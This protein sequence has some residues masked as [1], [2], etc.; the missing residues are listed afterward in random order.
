MKKN[1]SRIFIFKRLLKS[2]VLDLAIVSGG[3]V[4]CGSGAFDG[5]FLDKRR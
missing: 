3:T 1:D 4:K 2:N 5:V